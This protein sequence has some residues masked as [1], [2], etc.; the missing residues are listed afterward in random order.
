[1]AR[2][3]GPEGARRTHGR[4][5]GD[6]RQQAPDAQRPLDRRHLGG[7][8]AGCGEPVD[9]VAESA[10]RDGLLTEAR[11]HAFDVRGVGGRR[12][13]DE[14]AAVLE[15]ASLGVQQVRGPVEGDHRLARARATGDLGDTPRGRADRLV[16][17]ALDGR[18]DVAHLAAAAAGEGG[19]ECAV[20][21][22][23]DVVGRLGHHEVV[24]DADDGGAFA[25]QDPAP[26]DA[27]RVDRG[28][29]VE[30]GGRGRAPVDDEGLVLVVADAE[31]ADVAD[32]AVGRR[33]P[34][35]TEV[36]AAEDQ[37]LV[38]LLDHRASARR[39]V[40]EGIALEEPGHLLVAHVAGAVG[41]APGQAV[42]LDVGRAQAR[43]G[44]LG[45]D[46]VDVRLLAGELT[47][48][49]GRG[50]GKA[51]VGGGHEAGSPRCAAQVTESPSLIP[52]TGRLSTV[53]AMPRRR[54]GCGRVE[55]IPRAVA[56]V[57]TSTRGAAG[58]GDPV[59][60]RRRWR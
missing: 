46:P 50:L 11:Q 19:D 55:V 3:E 42:G 36:E 14:D 20:A 53:H 22:D 39:G 58:G 34:L 9:E 23:D 41:A 59:A 18:D 6:A 45:V 54:R 57:F 38:L 4:R 29:P 25:P 60:P 17:V 26:H 32:L 48:D 5:R 33:G 30:R 31:P 52:A 12:P 16:L 51:R 44:Q 35:G 40:H 27:H 24:L 56:S 8:E 13:D 21:H 37:P 43:L 10:Q 49:V 2:D 28:R 47:G 15:A 1:M 7:V